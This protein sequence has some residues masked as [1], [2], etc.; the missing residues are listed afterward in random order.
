MT[1]NT[2]NYPAKLSID[3]P[4]RLLNRLTSFFRIFTIIPIAI[5]LGLLTSPGASWGHHTH[6]WSMG[7][8]S[9]VGIL[10]LDPAADCFSAKI[11]EMVV[12]LESEYYSVRRRECSVTWHWLPMCI[13]QPTKS[14][15]YILI[16]RIRMLKKTC[17]VGIRFLNGFLSYPSL[18]R[19]CLFMHPGCCLRDYCLVC[20][21]FQR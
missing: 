17:T 14:R 20:D 16:S 5:V 21:S 18:Y 4:E 7:A 11:P 1:D 10:F 2:V 15:L 9:R 13:R 8:A 19:S 12:R 6:N 3:Y